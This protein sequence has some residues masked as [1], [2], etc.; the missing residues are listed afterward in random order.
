VDQRRIGQGFGA[1]GFS[2]TSVAPLAWGNQAKHGKVK[3]PGLGRLRRH[4]TSAW[5]L[6]GHILK[7]NFVLNIS[8]VVQNKNHHKYFCSHQVFATHQSTKSPT[9]NLFSRP[10]PQHKYTSRQ[11]C[12]DQSKV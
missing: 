6:T 1:Q 12:H 3:S 8:L 2:F 10:F 7:W 11:T 5:L 9:G 4:H